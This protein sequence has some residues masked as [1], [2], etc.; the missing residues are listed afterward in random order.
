MAWINGQWVDDRPGFGGMLG[1]FG[2]QPR[3]AAGYTGD[4]SLDVIGG[5]MQSPPFGD[6]PGMPNLPPQMNPPGY[7]RGP[8][9]QPPFGGGLGDITPWNPVQTPEFQPFP[10][11]PQLP[12]QPP[13]MRPPR[14]YDGPQMYPPMDIPGLRPAPQPIPGPPIP[15][16]MPAPPIPPQVRPP[17]PP[18]PPNI[19]DVWE[20][21]PPPKR[22]TGAEDRAR[23]LAQ[24]KARAAAKRARDL[25]SQKRAA[26]NQ[27]K[28]D[29][30]RQKA[31]AAAKR[32]ADK[33]KKPGGSK[34]NITPRRTKE[35]RGAGKGRGYP[36]PPAT[37]TQDVAK[38]PK[39]ART[40]TG[41]SRSQRGRGDR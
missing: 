13:Q 32:A 17:M 25:A 34:L 38:G 10:Q 18:P 33:A 3:F 35:V 7:S 36:P 1:G 20:P 11:P 5:P 24:Q 15:P 26:A 41:I 19:G 21:T 4:T 40:I 12:T 22:D 6:R 27:R 14:T 31:A 9:M 29:L 2:G 8:Q 37:R 16:R 39:G 30:A 28:A 23:K